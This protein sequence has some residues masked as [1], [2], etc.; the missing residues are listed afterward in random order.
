[1]ANRLL[2]LPPGSLSNTSG[3]KERPVRLPAK[4]SGVRPIRPKQKSAILRWARLRRR[5]L[6]PR[7]QVVHAVALAVFLECHQV[8]NR[9]IR[10]HV[11]QRGVGS[12]PVGKGWMRGLILDALLAHVDD[13]T[14][15]DALQI[16]LSG[17][18]HGR[19]PFT[20]ISRKTSKLA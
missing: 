18:E 20:G 16:F 3:F 12:C 15:A 11:E 13:A 6:G 7:L 2:R 4:A 14:V 8:A 9:R 10:F 17:H 5:I 19:E 1:M